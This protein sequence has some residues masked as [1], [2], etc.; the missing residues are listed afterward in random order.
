MRSSLL[1]TIL[2]MRMLFGVISTSSSSA[3]NSRDCS[4]AQHGGR[5][6]LQC[7]VGAGRAGIGDMLLLADIDDDVL[8][9]GACADDH[10]LVNRHAGPNETCG[11]GPVQ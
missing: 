1:S 9:F 6:Q 11:R 4:R 5:G 10:A 8:A 7:F 2:R 3:M